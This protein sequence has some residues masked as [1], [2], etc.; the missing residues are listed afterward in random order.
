MLLDHRLHRIAFLLQPTPPIVLRSAIRGFY[1]VFLIL[2]LLIFPNRRMFRL[3]ASLRCNRN[4]NRRL[5][6]C[7]ISAQRSS[8]LVVSLNSSYFARL[9]SSISTGPVTKRVVDQPTWLAP[10]AMQ[11]CLFVFFFMRSKVFF[12]K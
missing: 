3:L 11:V 10:E 1:F 4:S 2:K 5:Q 7:A 8:M 9:N 6:S 12:V